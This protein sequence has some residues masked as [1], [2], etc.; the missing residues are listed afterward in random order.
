MVA[1]ALIGLSIAM[2]LFLLAAGLTLVFGMLGVINFA[3]GAIYMLGAFGAFEVYRTTGSFWLALIVAPLAVA[4]IGAVMEMVL[5]RPLYDRDHVEQLL[6]T[7]GAILV[8]E[9]GVRMVWGLGYR[10]LPLPPALEGSLTVLG[11]D[12]A[13]Y[14]LFLL[15]AGTAVGAGL[16]LLIEKTRLGMVLRAA[17]SY[18]T[19]V[20]ALGIRID[21][22]RTI[23][24][25]V[26]A[27]LAALAGAIAAPIVPIQVG[28]SFTIIVDCFVVVI[29]GGLGNIRG[30]IAAA[31]LLGLVQAFGQHYFPSWIEVAT[32][33]VLIGVL[34]V[35]PQGLFSVAPARKA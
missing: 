27:A 19:M 33:L 6:M 2:L 30:A 31:I 10:D 17:M 32:Y 22:V 8:I 16:F 3:H 34:L 1:T 26:G 9:E 14:R 5:L 4:V 35:R 7:F 15:A 20:R 28:M 21:R 11:D 18:P 13:V 23:V 12:V 29:L 25:A 24:F